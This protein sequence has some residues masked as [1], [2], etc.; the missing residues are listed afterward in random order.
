MLGIASQIN[1]L[2]IP[3]SGKYLF[4]K[5]AEKEKTIYVLNAHYGP[6]TVLNVR[7]GP[8]KIFLQNMLS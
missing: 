6:R 8:M 2:K 1:K 7:E 5:L 4:G 3:P